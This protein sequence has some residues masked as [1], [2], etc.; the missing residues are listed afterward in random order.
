MLRPS[1]LAVTVLLCLLPSCGR[2]QDNTPPANARVTTGAGAVD[3]VKTRQLKKRLLGTLDKVATTVKASKDTSDAD[4]I[5]NASYAT[6]KALAAL[7]RA[8][9][10][11]G[12]FSAMIDAEERNFIRED[13]T[14]KG[15][16]GKILNGTLGMHA[17]Y[18]ILYS[19]RYA[20]N[21]ARM[22]AVDSMDA[23]ITRK[24]QS[25]AQGIAIVAVAANNVY[26]MVRAIIEDM[27]REQF[28]AGHLEQVGQVYAE[29]AGSAQTDED[30]FLNGLYRTFEVSQVWALMLEP[31]QRTALSEMNRQLIGR[32]RQREGVGNQMASGME[33][34]Y[35]ITAYITR[36]TIDRS[37]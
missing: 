37:L 29:G 20:G 28:F 26:G 25:G 2:T 11:K 30:R 8:W 35:T 27:D 24:M 22:H 36:T 12:E 21:E 9:D 4:R 15:K 10:P 3:T 32:T 5:A 13:S 23:A 17:M 6:F 14:R 34:L 18:K 1:L 33:F 31:K 16:A 19:M 7:A